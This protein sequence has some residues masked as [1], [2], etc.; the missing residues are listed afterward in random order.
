MS[1]HTPEPLRAGDLLEIAMNGS[2]FPVDR[3]LATYADPNNWAQIYNGEG[4][5]KHDDCSSLDFKLA[6]EAQANP[7]PLRSIGLP[8]M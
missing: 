7:G 3:V 8:C 2:I 1:T 5:A 4:D 6:R